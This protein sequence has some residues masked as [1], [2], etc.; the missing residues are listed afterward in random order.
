MDKN[1]VIGLVLLCVFALSLLG[2]IFNGTFADLSSKSFLIILAFLR[3][4][5][6]CLVLDLCSYSK[7]PISKIFLI[8]SLL[9]ARAF[10][11]YNYHSFVIILPIKKYIYYN[12][13]C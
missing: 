5:V 7:N 8:T 1:K 11:Y 4:L 3:H 6:R 2:C 10:F 12:F 13:S 9:F